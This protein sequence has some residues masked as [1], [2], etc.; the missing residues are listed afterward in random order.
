M[1]YIRPQLTAGL[2]QL[3]R[4]LKRSLR[5]GTR[6]TP[7]LCSSTQKLWNCSPYS[8]AVLSQA[9]HR[10]LD[11]GTQRV[12]EVVFPGP[13]KVGPVPLLLQPPPSLHLSC[14]DCCL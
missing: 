8:V 5:C 10:D 12:V 7:L 3:S 9:V 4:E 13:L 1:S 2:Q 11:A 6:L 14:A